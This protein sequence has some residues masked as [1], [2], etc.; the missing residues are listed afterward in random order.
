MSIITGDSEA[1]VKVKRVQFGILGLIRRMS[2]TEGGINFN[3][4]YLLFSFAI[5]QPTTLTNK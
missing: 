2:V 5:P 1:P 3:S 4:D